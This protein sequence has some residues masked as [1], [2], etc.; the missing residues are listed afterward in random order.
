MQY[1]LFDLLRPAATGAGTAGGHS[2][3]SGAQAQ[4]RDTNY[5]HGETEGSAKRKIYFTFIWI[6]MPKM[7]T[8]YLS[9]SS[10]V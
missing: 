9:P 10:A 7:Y 2:T 8:Q 3:A 6:F 5:G 1:Y 4:G